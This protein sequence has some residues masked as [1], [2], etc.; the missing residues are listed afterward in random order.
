MFWFDDGEFDPTNTDGSSIAALKQISSLAGGKT[1]LATASED[2]LVN[3]ATRPAA[4]CQELKR[5]CRS[6]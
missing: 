5:R 3:V 6:A 4:P 1:W 2:G